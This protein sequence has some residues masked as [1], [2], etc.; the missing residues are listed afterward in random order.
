MGNAPPGRRARVAATA[1][2]QPCVQ[3][4]YRDVTRIRR[5]TGPVVKV[6][7]I[8]DTVVAKG[9]RILV[10]STPTATTSSDV[11]ELRGAY[12]PVWAARMMAIPVQATPT[13]RR[14]L[15]SGSANRV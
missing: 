9:V 10:L 15:A 6:M 12:V 3:K 2:T 8:V 7:R 4:R 14:V 1:A 13:A 11:T 5:I